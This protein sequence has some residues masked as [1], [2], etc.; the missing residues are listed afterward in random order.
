VSKE[1]DLFFASYQE[2]ALGN[3]SNVLRHSEGFSV[4]LHPLHR[5]ERF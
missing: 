3:F 1:Q 2:G 4:L 5:F